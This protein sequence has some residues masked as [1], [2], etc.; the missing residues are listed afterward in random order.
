MVTPLCGC[1]CVYSGAQAGAGTGVCNTSGSG[2]DLPSDSG[3]LL[4]SH[5]PL[6]TSDSL[7]MGFA[8][9][10]TASSF[11]DR[12]SN[13][14]T[15][16]E[17]EGRCWCLRRFSFVQVFLGH[18]FSTHGSPEI[19]MRSHEIW[20]K[21]NHFKFSTINQFCYSFISQK[22]SNKPPF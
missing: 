5:G 15:S 14:A 13:L 18:C 2:T 3:D 8:F 16:D 7:F 11:N 20:V 17:D 6:P 1:V 10:L 9:L 12:L 19:Q 21:C 4:S 22:I